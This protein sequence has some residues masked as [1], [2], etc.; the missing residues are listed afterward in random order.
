MI[1]HHI[2]PEDFC[3]AVLSDTL[4]SSTCQLVYEWLE[5]MEATDSLSIDA[6]NAMYVGILTDTGGFRHATSPRLFRV[7]AK[8]L[9]KGVDNNKMSDLVFNA[10]STNSFNLLA[11]AYHSGWKY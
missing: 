3:Q 4:S 10:Y 8:M 9:E 11:F 1:D 5:Q 2:G 7:V 6:L